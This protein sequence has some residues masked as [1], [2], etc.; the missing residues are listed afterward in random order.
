MSSFLQRDLFQGLIYYRH[1]GEEVFEDSFDFIL[2]DSH[3]PPNLSEQQAS[4]YSLNNTS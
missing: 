2:S 3:Q 4:V 1:L